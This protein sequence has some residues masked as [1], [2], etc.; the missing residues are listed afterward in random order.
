MYTQITS[1]V[2]ENT[3]SNSI[4]LW[5]GLAFAFLTRC[6][7]VIILLRPHTR[8]LGFRAVGPVPDCPWPS[9]WGDF[10]TNKKRSLGHK[11]NWNLSHLS[12][13]S[14]LQTCVQFKS[15]Q[16]LWVSAWEWGMGLAQWFSLLSVNIPIRVCWRGDTWMGIRGGRF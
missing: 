15:S 11:Q 10:K 4:L 5:W 16:W 7:I 13:L 8:L 3:D 14:W 12:N 2:N 1:S 6:L 9:P